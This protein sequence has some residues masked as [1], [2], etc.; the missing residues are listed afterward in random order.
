[1]LRGQFR[2]RR[3]VRDQK[4]QALIET[5]LSVLFLIFLLLGTTEFARL[6]Y[7]AIEV[8]NAAKSAVQYAAQNGATAGDSA[9]IQT[10]A[11]NDASN[12]T[13][14]ATVQPLSITCS[15][16][17]AYS[18]TTGCAVGTV[19]VTTVTVK[20]TATIA[21]LIHIV[22]F[23]GAMTLHGQASQVVGD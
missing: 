2:I 10:A 9:G 15:D 11:S 5:S 23:S 12:L 7:A 16:G 8:S 3:C 19:A 14:T 13:V 17:S 1:M 20:T 4:G 22:G 18:I 21:P 6:A